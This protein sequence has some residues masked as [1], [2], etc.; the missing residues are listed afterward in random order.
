MTSSH[1]F[2]LPADCIDR[3]HKVVQRTDILEFDH[4]GDLLAYADS[5]HILRIYSISQNTYVLRRYF[6]QPITTVAFKSLDLPG[7]SSIF[8]GFDDGSIVL[9]AFPHSVYDVRVISPAIECPTDI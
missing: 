9:L 8:L 2:T 3:H 1:V 6:A 4:S 7:R 5:D